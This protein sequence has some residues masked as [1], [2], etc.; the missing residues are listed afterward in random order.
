MA[1]EKMIELFKIFLLFFKIGIF[2]I[3]GGIVMIPLIK[4]EVVEKKKWM[5]EDE[6][7][8]CI[9]ISQSLPGV[10]AINMATYVGQFRKGIAGAIAGTIGVIMPSFIAIIA[11]IEFLGFAGNNQYVIGAITGLKAGATALAVFATYSVSRN[12]IKGKIGLLVMIAT[13]VLIAI[14]SVNAVYLVIVGLI[15]G[16]LFGRD[17]K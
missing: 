13:F 9:V 16:I 17:I 2:T 11:V 1:L 8:D 4:R 6:A 5:T 12:V 10:I 14:F 3:G 15:A 7:I